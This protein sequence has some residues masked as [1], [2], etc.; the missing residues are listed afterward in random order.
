MKDIHIPSGDTEEKKHVFKTSNFRKNAS[1]IKHN[2]SVDE[3]LKVFDNDGTTKNMPEKD[4][5]RK[6]SEWLVQG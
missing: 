6:R 1:Y 4:M 2:E 5:L 3:R